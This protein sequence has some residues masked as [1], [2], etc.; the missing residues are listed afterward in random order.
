MKKMVVVIAVAI[1]LTGL[2]SAQVK[3]KCHA[4]GDEITCTSTDV[5]PQ[6]DSDYRQGSFGPIYDPQLAAQHAYQRAYQAAQAR[7]QNAQTDT[8]RAAC[9]KLA[10][11]NPSITCK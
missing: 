9:L 11:D 10:V 5:T 7:S 1:L 8:G 2:A 4:S 6:P 3:T